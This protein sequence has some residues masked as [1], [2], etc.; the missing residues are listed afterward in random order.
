MR[1]GPS[2]N[3]PIKFQ[4]GMFEIPYQFLEF[5]ERKNNREGFSEKNANIIDERCIVPKN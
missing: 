5:V 4:E 3:Y 1:L 2:K